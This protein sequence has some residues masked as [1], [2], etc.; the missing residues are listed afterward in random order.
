MRVP[1]RDLTFREFAPPLGP[2]QHGRRSSP[3]QGRRRP[4]RRLCLLKGCEKPFQPRH[5][6]TRY[7]SEACRQAARRWRAWRARRRYRSTE[8]GKACRCRQS[9]R[10]RERCHQRQAR[11][12]DAASAGGRVGQRAAPS[13]KKSSCSRPGCYTCFD[14]HPR[15]PL[16]RFCC[17]L[18]RRALQRVLEREARWRRRARRR[19]PRSGF[20]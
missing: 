3:V 11:A 19:R 1:R 4:R 17:S 2:P 13:S 15:S 9:R 5:P 6:Q 18:C 8:Q 7:C 10:Y 16:Q 12:A 14:P 20:G